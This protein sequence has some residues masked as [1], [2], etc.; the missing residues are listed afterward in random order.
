MFNVMLFVY[1]IISKQ[2]YVNRAYVIYPP[3]QN[4]S[5]NVK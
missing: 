4:P 3:L 2:T 5:Y 1:I